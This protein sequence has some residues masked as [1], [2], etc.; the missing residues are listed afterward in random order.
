MPIVPFESP[1]I[2]VTETQRRFLRRLRDARSVGLPR[3]SIPES[4]HV[5]VTSLKT[6]GAVEFRPS[7]AGRGVVLCIANSQAF[8]TFIAARLPQGLDVDL[9]EI[10][11]RAQAVAMLADAKAVRRGSSQGVFVRATKPGVVLFSTDGQVFIPVSELTLKAGGSGIQLAADRSWSFAGSI[12]V[13]ENEE[14]F[15]RHD[16]VLPD[17]DLAVFASG[18]MSN[19]LLDWLASP[20]MEQCAIIHWGDYDPVGVYQFLRLVDKCP[21][22]VTVY[23]PAI[24]DGLLARIGKPKLVARQARYLDSIRS[25]ESEPYV[26]RMIGLFDRHRRGSRRKRCFE[27]VS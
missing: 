2:I 18:N 26:G 15:W 11:D 13:V 21:G 14:V 10:A 9:A 24:V 16:E 25:R 22:R 20:A 19:R 4:C 17:V 6:C 1:E 27:A 23:A 5:L 8:N 7:R 3:S 12:V